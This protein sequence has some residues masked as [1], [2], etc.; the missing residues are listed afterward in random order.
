MD[1]FFINMA[2]I[3]V[4][5]DEGKK[6]ILD[7][8]LPLVPKQASFIRLQSSQAGDFTWTQ[9]SRSSQWAG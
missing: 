5:W 4:N 1:K 3:K 9:P 7:N 8:Y 6:D 2:V